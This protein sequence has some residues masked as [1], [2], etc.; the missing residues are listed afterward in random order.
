[1]RG[2]QPV[3]GPV[4]AVDLE[5]LGAV[6]ALQFGET[7]QRHPRRARHELDELGAVLVR[8]GAQRQPEPL[9]L[10]DGRGMSVNWAET[11]RFRGGFNKE[12]L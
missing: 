12:I 8:E 1:M 5:L 11:G 10:R 7:L 3:G 9:D 6:H 4:V 2:G